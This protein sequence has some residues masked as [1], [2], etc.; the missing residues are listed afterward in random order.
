M[1]FWDASPENQANKYGTGFINCFYDYHRNLSP[2]EYVWPLEKYQKY[3]E[4]DLMHDLFEVG[5]VDK[6]IFQPTYLKE[7]Y[8]KG[9]NT[10]EDNGA[11]VAQAPGQADP[12]RRLRPAPR[13]GGPGRLRGAR[14]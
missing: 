14:A 9:F 8:V 13:R 3:S 2:E 7:F 1:H 4:E 11:L 5:Y 6:A 10:T 12:Q